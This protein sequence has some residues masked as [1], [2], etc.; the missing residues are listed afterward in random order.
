MIYSQF[1]STARSLL[2]RLKHDENRS[3]LYEEQCDAIVSLFETWLTASDAIDE[4][5]LGVECVIQ[6]LEEALLSP[7]SVSSPEE[8]DSPYNL[9]TEEVDSPFNSDKDESP[10]PI[11]ALY[12]RLCPGGFTRDADE[13]TEEATNPDANTETNAGSNANSKQIT[14]R[15]KKGSS[16]FKRKSKGSMKGDYIPVSPVSRKKEA[17]LAK[18]AGLQQ[19]GMGRINHSL[20]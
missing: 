16:A 6:K 20:R 14:K 11:I 15:R 2:H 3:D 9:P 18:E 17:S 7:T 5:N 8:V 19:I 1:I 13:L 4:V 12:K 10:A